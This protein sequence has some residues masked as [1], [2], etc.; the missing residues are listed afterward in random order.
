MN[1][2]VDRPDL[3]PARS[4][5]N[6]VPTPYSLLLTPYFLLL[7]PYFLLLTPYSLLLTPNSQLPTPISFL[8]LQQHSIQKDIRQSFGH[9]L[10]FLGTRTWLG[11]GFVTESRYDK[12]A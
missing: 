1:R 11:D 10:H 7:T 4:P 6:S 8:L 12:H 5:H 3:Q 2:T 9:F